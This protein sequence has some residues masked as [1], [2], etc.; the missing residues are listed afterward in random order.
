MTTQTYKRKCEPCSYAL[1]SSYWLPLLSGRMKVHIVCC[2]QGVSLGAPT[3]QQS[4]TLTSNA[5]SLS[6]DS[7]AAVP[8]SVKSGVAHGKHSK[9][10]CTCACHCSLRF[11]RVLPAGSKHTRCGVQHV[12]SRSC[13]LQ[14]LTLKLLFGSQS[15]VMDICPLAMPAAIKEH[16]AD[17]ATR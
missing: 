6:E 1:N 11:R 5:Y 8:A 14:L 16:G 10:A 15:Y 2:F 13:A 3:P 7:E 12:A 17:P 9:C 4:A